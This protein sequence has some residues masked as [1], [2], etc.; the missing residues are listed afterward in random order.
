MNKQSYTNE[1]NYLR[2]CYMRDTYEWDFYL[3]WRKNIVWLKS[4]DINWW[5]LI[6]EQ[7]IKKVTMWVWNIVKW[8]VEEK[9]YESLDLFFEEITSVY[10]R[11]I[12]Q[13]LSS[14]K[15]VEKAA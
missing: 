2:N 14:G 6:W 5:E 9:D 1:P 13:A 10:L 15:K 11:R 8:I 7:T 4:K 3:D 12:F